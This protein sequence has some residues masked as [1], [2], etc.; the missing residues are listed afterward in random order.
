MSRRPAIPPCL[1]TFF[2]DCRVVCRSS[3]S[4]AAEPVAAIRSAW[5]SEF[6]SWSFSVSH[7]ALPC[8]EPEHL[9][10]CSSTPRG[11]KSS[12]TQAPCASAIAI[13]A[14]AP[15]IHCRAGA[16]ARAEKRSC[17]LFCGARSKVVGVSSARARQ[18]IGAIGASRPD[19]QSPAFSLQ[20]HSAATLFGGDTLHFPRSSGP[21]LIGLSNMTA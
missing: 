1:H 21:P 13:T 3:L 9:Y 4:K 17:G 15:F 6:P 14:T 20:P 5:I 2:A 7:P 11:P 12:L 10:H 8:P 18:F 16:P 19:L